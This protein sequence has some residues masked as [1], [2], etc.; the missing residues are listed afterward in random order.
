MFLMKTKIPYYLPISLYNC[1]FYNFLLFC[2][3][4][5]LIYADPMLHNG[6]F[7]CGNVVQERFNVEM[8]KEIII[9]LQM[10]QCFILEYYYLSEIL[11]NL[12]QISQEGNYNRDVK[13]WCMVSHSCRVIWIYKYIWYPAA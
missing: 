8:N 4:I 9:D 3:F 10:Q 5:M 6:L 11:Q 12:Q 7:K 1:S 2:H 13:V